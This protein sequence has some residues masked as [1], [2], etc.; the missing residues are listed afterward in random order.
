MKSHTTERFIERGRI[1]YGDKYDYSKVNYINKKV[2]V[3]IICPIHGEFT[4]APC[5]HLYGTYGCTQCGISKI[6]NTKNKPKEKVIISPEDKEIKRK[7]LLDIKRNNFISKSIEVHGNRYDY[8]KVDYSDSKKKIKI[9]CKIHGEFYQRPSAHTYGQG[10]MGCRLDT[11][12]IGLDIFLDRCKEVHGDRYDYSLITEYKNSS[13][14]VDVI[15][16]DHGVFK[17][18]PDNHTNRKQGCPECK[19][20]GLENFIKRSSEIHNNKYDYS[21]VTEYV[22]NKTKVNIICEKHGVFNIR[23]GDHMNDEIGCAECTLDR[24]RTTTEDFIKRSN[25][26]HCNKYKYSSNIEFRSNRD[27]IEIECSKHGIFKQRVIS[28]LNGSGCP[29][30]KRPKGEIEISKELE[31]MN[32]KYFEQHKFIDCKFINMLRFDFYLPNENICI[33]YNGEQH[34]RPVSIFGGEKSF[35]TQI[36]KDEIKRKYCIDNNIKLIVIRYDENVVDVL[37][38]HFKDKKR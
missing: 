23:I 3:I 6:N 1:K 35:K 33:E 26:K 19:K 5:N 20:V 11:R 22:N 18:D 32:I 7:E 12:K 28:H 13:T 31:K 30:C 10:C 25:I 29:K 37:N 34:Y 8:S 21:L 38:E 36:L 4:Q 17:I 14:K 24:F 2:H 9:I 27:K 15:C 16:K